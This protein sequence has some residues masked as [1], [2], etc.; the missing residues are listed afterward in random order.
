MK[1]IIIFGN[2]VDGF[3]YVGPFD[4]AEA[5]NEYAERYLSGGNDWW[6]VLLQEP[7]P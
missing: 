2:P 6:V 7:S 1:H 5:A 4:D 3:E